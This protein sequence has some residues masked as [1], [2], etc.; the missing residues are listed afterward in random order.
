MNPSLKTA[1]K[2]TAQIFMGMVVSILLWFVAKILIIR[3]ISKDEFGIYS[4]VV[5][6]GGIFS[7]L[8]TLGLHEGIARYVSIFLGEGKKERAKAFYRDVLNLG[9]IS[10]FSICAVLFIF[11]GIVSRYIF[12]KPE[13]EI[14]LRIISF[15]IPFFV[16][17]SVMVG[18]LRGF[19]IIQAKIYADVGQP[20]FFL[21]IL[22]LFFVFHFPFMSIIYAYSSSMAIV[23]ILISV[24]GMKKIGLSPFF[25]RDEGNSR[26]LLKFS[27]PLLTVS[28]LA[29]VLNSTDTIMLGRYTSSEDVGIYNVSISLARLLMFPLNALGFVFMPLSGEMYSRGQIADLKRTYQVLTKWIFSATLPIFFILFFFPEMSL[30]FLF[31]ERFINSVP[32]LRI[33]SAGFLFHTFTGVNGLLMMVIGM[34][35][36]LM[37][38]YIIGTVMNVIFNYILIKQSGMGITGAAYATVISYL[39]INTIISM[40]L[41]RKNKIHPFTP[42]YIKPVIGSAIIGI[43]IYVIAKSLPLYLWMMPIYLIIFLGGYGISLFVTR[44]LDT[45][46]FSLL[47]AVFEK[48]GISTG[49]IQRLSKANT[50]DRKKY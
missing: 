36:E 37:N 24:Y 7:L 29:I 38:I 27:L 3:N 16:M 4:L 33:L 45:E 2:G 48:M 39:M 41:Y 11:S 18:I 13:L 20:F 14:P 6:I 17:S 30:T 21:I 8:A 31:G 26:E 15:F 23:L 9:I 12:Y 46:D 32:S 49:W 10:S 19:N 42:Q 47:K 43:I 35:G 1:V 28:A 34:S 25:F 50:N 5:A 22:S 40:R 44:S